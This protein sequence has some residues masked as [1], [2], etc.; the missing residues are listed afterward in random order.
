MI[1]EKPGQEIEKRAES[2]K[3]DSAGNLGTNEK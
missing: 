1:E 2:I 3:G